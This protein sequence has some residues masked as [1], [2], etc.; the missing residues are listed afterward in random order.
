M[1]IRRKLGLHAQTLGTLTQSPGSAFFL[2]ANEAR[3]KKNAGREGRVGDGREVGD[4]APKPQPLGPLVYS[5][6]WR[7]RDVLQ[8]TNAE[9]R[10]AWAV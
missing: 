6:S 2:L 9:A 3:T 8:K 4:W 7:M 5:F 1:D 10:S